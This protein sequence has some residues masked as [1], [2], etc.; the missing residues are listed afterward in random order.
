[1]FLFFQQRF[2]LNFGYL[3]EHGVGGI[4][5]LP[6]GNVQAGQSSD[7]I[8]KVPSADK[9]KSQLVHKLAALRVELFVKILCQAKT[10]HGIEEARLVKTHKYVAQIENNIL[11]INHY[12]LLYSSSTSY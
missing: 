5:Y 1:M 2:L 3:H 6:V 11:K 12:S 8:A 7:I 9:A 10:C 4:N